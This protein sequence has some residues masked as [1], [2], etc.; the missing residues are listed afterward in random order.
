MNFIIRMF[1]MFVFIG[2]WQA[3]GLAV[4][5]WLALLNGALMILW[6]LSALT[7]QA[8]ASTP[9]YKIITERQYDESN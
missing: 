9:G 4:F 3:T 1:M 2:A 6:G 7:D 8:K 5:G